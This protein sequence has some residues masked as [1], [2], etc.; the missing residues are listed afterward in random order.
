MLLVHRKILPSV[1]AFRLI[2]VPQQALPP[3]IPLRRLVANWRVLTSSN[4]ESNNPSSL[5]MW[6][7][8]KGINARVLAATSTAPLEAC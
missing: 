7:G 5:H 8:S 6:W 2:L 4:F 3:H 1:S